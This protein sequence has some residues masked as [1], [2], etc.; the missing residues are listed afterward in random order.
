MWEHKRLCFSRHQLDLQVRLS[1]F[2]LHP[3]VCPKNSL[4]RDGKLRLQKG[5]ALERFGFGVP[6]FHWYRLL[7]HQIQLNSSPSSGCCS[8]AKVE[9]ATWMDGWRGQEK[10]DSSS[11]KVLIKLG[12]QAMLDPLFQ[13]QTD[14]QSIFEGMDLVETRFNHSNFWIAGSLCS[15]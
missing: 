11:S 9:Q 10:K 2:M 14:R 1:F 12:L 3:T 4:E 5:H 6:A 13:W 7:Q 8:N 15:D